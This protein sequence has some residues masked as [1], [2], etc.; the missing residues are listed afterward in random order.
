[1]RA[2]KARLAGAPKKRL[3]KSSSASF[4][5]IALGPA[6][7]PRIVFHA[8]ALRVL[9]T[10]VVADNLRV[11]CALILLAHRFSP[12]CF[13]IYPYYVRSSSIYTEKIF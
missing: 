4:A 11:L 6:F 8:G 13:S 2:K 12:L 7:F 1:L 3:L 10:D 9:R 5:G